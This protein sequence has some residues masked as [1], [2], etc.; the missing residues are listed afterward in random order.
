MSGQFS[1]YFS[2]ANGLQNRERRP[3]RSCDGCRQRKCDGHKTAHGNCSSCLAFGSVCTYSEKPRKRGPKN[4]TVEELK[5]ENETLKEKLRALSLCSLCSQQPQAL[6]GSGDPSSSRSI[7]REGSPDTEEGAAASR[8]TEP[9]DEQDLISEELADKI[10]QI[11]L[12][13]ESTFFGPGSS[14]GLVN[15]A[16]AMKEK[17]LGSSTFDTRRPLYHEILPWE[18]AAFNKRKPVHVFPATDLIASLLELYFTNVHPTVPLLHRP[19]FEKSVEDGLHRTNTD[20]GATLLAVLAVASRYSDDPRVFVDGDG[21]LSSGWK[22]ADQIQI[23]Q[24]MFS[25]SIYE[26]QTYALLT[27]FV[28]GTSVPQVSWLYIGLGIRFLQQR[29]EHRRKRGSSPPSSEDES[30]KRAF[31]SFVMF[32]RISCLF[33]GRPMGLHVEDYD[34]EFP[35]AVDD[36]FWE[37]GFNQPPEKPSQLAYFICHLRLSEILA[38]A[39]RRL[40]GSKKSKM[41]LGWDGPDWEHRAIAQLD[42]SMNDFLDSIPE[43]LRWDAT[44]PPTGTFFDQ[45]A[46]LHI[47]Y[48]HILI[49]IHRPYIQRAT[50]QGAPSLAICARAARAILHAAEIWLRKLQRVPLPTLINPVFVSG[51]VL[52]V[53]MLATKRAG[54]P[55]NKSKKDLAHI[56]TAMELLRVAETRLQP[57]GRLW[58]KLRDIG[59]ELLTGT[60]A[61]ESA[62]AAVVASSES[63]N[64]NLAEI[65]QPYSLPDHPQDSIPPEQSTVASNFWNNESFSAPSYPSEPEIPMEE[66]MAAFANPPQNAGSTFLDDELMSMWMTPVEYGNM[67]W[68]NI[69]DLMTEFPVDD[70]KG[71][72]GINQF[73]SY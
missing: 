68:A 28:L 6:P 10:G 48:N 51:L 49:A 2:T 61:N 39:L 38:D 16:I 72:F 60:S 24:K 44:N 73:G 71:Q 12:R 23:L 31:W 32:E 1:T 15:N 8:S 58:E 57:M 53:Y 20:F 50:T 52:I 19:S 45:A 5:K 21:A 59:S 13:T 66:L 29:G 46:L 36:E 63:F 40:Y 67:T 65:S 25:P 69:S 35:L 11:S 3:H 37:T 41:L 34:I 70:D 18:R 47:F 27:I 43:H 62:G 56:A 64:S 33:L 55:I 4:R 54:F 7:V 30:W 26:V 22:F 14:F 9:P 42:S 17:Y